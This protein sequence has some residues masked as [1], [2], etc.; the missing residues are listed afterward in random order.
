M[1]QTENYISKAIAWAREAGNLQ[2]EYF[3]RHGLQIQTKQ[4]ASDVVTAAD[5]ASERL[6]TDHIL[7]CC[8]GHS[9]LSEESGSMGDT[10]SE[11]R[12]VIDPLDGTT[13]F[14]QGLPVFCVS[15][16]LQRYGETVGAIV[17]AP[18]LGEIFH[19]IKGKGAWL[20]GAPIHCA[21][22]KPLEECVMATGVPYD[23]ADNP[24]NNLENILNIAPRVRGIRRLGSAALDLCYVGAGFIDAYWELNLN[25][26][27]VEAGLLIVTEAGGKQHRLA[28]RRGVS[29]AAGSPEGLNHLL[30]LLK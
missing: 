19:A 7:E 5:K 3:R 16:A 12:W 21:E 1:T 18:Y 8:P 6:L 26:W 23:K 14:S 17:N 24:D 25:P 28:D 15:I 10:D 22:A 27:D 4:N 11:W 30:A 20:N 2:L 29:V 13:N 9:I